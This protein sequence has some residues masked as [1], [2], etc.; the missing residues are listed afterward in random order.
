MTYSTTAAGAS[1]LA[2]ETHG[3]TKTYGNRTVVDRLDLALPTGVVAGFVGPNGAGKSTTLRMLLGLVRPSS[4]DGRVLGIPLNRPQEYLPQ[5]GALIEAPAFYPALTGTA[6]LRVLATLGG[7]RTERV[8][9]VL[10][11]VGLG[12]RGDDPYKAYS[13]GMKQRL[14]IAAALLARPRLLVL[15]EPTNGLD[16]DGIR[17]MRALVRSIADEGP[18]VLV[19][20]HLLGEVQQVCDWL[21]MV[22]DGRQL[23]QGRTA[24]LLSGNAGVRIR[25]EHPAD[26]PRLADLLHRS[27]FEA[28]V[29]GQCL[30]LTGDGLD[31]G[32]LAAI[33]RTTAAG[34]ITL[35]EL[36]RTAATLEE[37]YGALVTGGVR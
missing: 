27:G 21:L 9:Q 14:G 10:D 11:R 15:D 29:D 19:S 1:D 31:D 13:L 32:V 26:L 35:V 5:V 24:D 20:S 33:N 34:G 17:G 12:D 23:Y 4:G 3:L 8:G 18:T 25:P 16:P 28:G 22:E 30:T 36:S 7:I 2:I 37:R 6:N